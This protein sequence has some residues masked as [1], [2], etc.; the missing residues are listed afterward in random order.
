MRP[1]TDG[2][3]KGLKPDKKI[4]L[5]SEL[6]IPPI[7]PTH[8]V[9]RVADLPQR[10]GFYR[11]HQ[12]LKHIAAFAGGVLEVTQ[13]VAVVDLF[14]GCVRRIHLVRGS[15]SPEGASALRAF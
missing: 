4:P 11:F 6:H 8:I 2:T 7:F 5:P 1:Q 13:A 10:V 15:V 12:R 9:Q 14:D 3:S